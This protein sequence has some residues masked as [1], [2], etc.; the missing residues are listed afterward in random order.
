M[1]SSAG[2]E[3]AP[4]TAA[5][6]S[7]PDFL[8][9]RSAALEDL[10]GGLGSGE[11]ALVFTSG[12]AI[13]AIGAQLLGI[14]RSLSPPQPG[15]R[16]HRHQQARRRPRRHLARHLQRARPHRRRRRPAP[17]LSLSVARDRDLY[18]AAPCRFRP[19]SSRTAAHVEIDGKIWKIVEFQ[20]VKPGKGGA[21]VRTK[22]RRIED[23]SV[24]DKTFR[25]GEKFRAV[26]TESKKMQYLYDSGDSAVFMDSRDYEQIEIPTERPRRRDEVGPAQRRGRGALRRRE[27]ERHRRCRARS[28]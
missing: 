6:Q 10:A 20:H 15:P 25:A 14:R 13:A 16:Q 8:G 19:T 5:A 26:R 9:S 11:A 22:L 12:G 7:W 1:P 18:A 2:S 28:R 4:T 21:F 27:A 17:H 23:G 3:A 24:I